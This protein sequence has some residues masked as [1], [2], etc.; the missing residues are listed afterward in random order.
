MPDFVPSSIPRGPAR[1]VR[2]LLRQEDA[3][4]LRQLGGQQPVLWLRPQPMGTAARH[5]VIG[6]R[7]SADGRLRGGLLADATAW[8]W[9][10]DSLSAIVL[11]HV[12]E[13]SSSA[14]GLLDEAARVLA[15]EG[16]L[17][18]LRFDRFS[19]WFWRY[20]RSLLR[21]SGGAALAL[22]MDLSSLRRHEL[23]LEYR[24]A[25]GPRGFRAEA[26]R[27]PAGRRLPER[28]PFASVFRATRAWVLR[29]R[30]QRL[31]VLGARDPAA[32]QVRNH[33]YGLAAGARRERE[34]QQ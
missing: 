21:R 31:I 23:T 26:E 5:G 19:P 24:H 9:A 17:Y 1:A 25:L 2:R 4:L 28:W 8:P 27:L 11:Q 22:P 33:G 3:W 10:D 13:G 14:P 12:I 30:R 16:R 15:P 7:A 20:G 32:R 29:K 34:E 6:L 18:L